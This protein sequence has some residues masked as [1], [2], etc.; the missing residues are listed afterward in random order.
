MHELWYSFLHSWA[1]GQ[2]KVSYWAALKEYDEENAVVYHPEIPLSALAYDEVKLIGACVGRVWAN[3]LYVSDL[4]VA[5]AYR[6]QG[7]AK[8]L[9]RDVEDKAKR[10][11]AVGAHTWTASYNAPGF[12]VK[13]GYE[14]ALELKD[15]PL[16]YS[17]F[18]CRKFF[19]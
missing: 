4:W 2:W 9:L 10:H 5:K 6:E 3:W 16:G 8:T 17:S 12:Y 7:L 11:N 13:Q 14:L 1:N 18:V 19:R 15:K